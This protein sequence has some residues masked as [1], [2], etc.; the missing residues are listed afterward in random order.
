MLWIVGDERSRERLDDDQD[1]G[2]VFLLV[3]AHQGSPGQRAVKRLLLSWLCRKLSNLLVLNVLVVSAVT[4]QLDRLFHVFT[5]LL[6]QPNF[7]TSSFTRDFWA[8]HRSSSHMYT[9]FM[10]N[11]RNTWVLFSSDYLVCFYH[12]PLLYAL[13]ARL[14]SHKFSVF[15]VLMSNNFNLQF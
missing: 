15:Q 9:S 10:Q 1:V 4:T 6:V 2:W 3:P 5:S 11:R 8:S 12:I 13:K 14:V 7:H